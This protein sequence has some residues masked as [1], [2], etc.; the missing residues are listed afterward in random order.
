MWQLDYIENIFNISLRNGVMGVKGTIKIKDSNTQDMGV[1]F[2]GGAI[3][4][5][6]H[7]QV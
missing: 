3:M 4:T 7:F 2:S 1:D 6:T 5:T